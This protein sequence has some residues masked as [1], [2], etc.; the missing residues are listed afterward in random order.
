MLRKILAVS[1]CAILAA[2]LITP[3][4]FAKNAPD[5]K[6]DFFKKQ[7]KRLKFIKDKAAGAEK[8]IDYV[9]SNSGNQTLGYDAIVSLSPG[10]TIGT[11]TY[12]T[13]SNSR[14]NRQVSWRGPVYK[15]VHFIWMRQGDST[16]NSNRGTAYEVWDATEGELAFAGAGGGCDIH[17]RLGS[18]SNYSGYV[19]LDVDTENK[20]VIANHHDEGA[21]Y[22]TTVWYDFGAANCFFSP[23]KKAMPDSVMEYG[24][25]VDDI[26][27]GSGVFIWPQHEYQVYNGDTITHVFAHQTEDNTPTEDGSYVHYF[28][29]IG[30]D[31]MGYWEY[32]PMIVDTVQTISQCVAA[33]RTTGKVALVWAAPPGAFPG[34]NESMTRHGDDPDPGL[35]WVG[36]TCDI[37]YMTSNDMG[38][39]WTAKE[40]ITDYDSTVGGWLTQGDMSVLI[41]TDE[42]LHILYAA[43]EALPTTASA[44]GGLGD[45][46]HFFGARLLHWDEKHLANRPVSDANWD[47]PDSACTGGAWNQCSINKPMLSE[48]DGKF[49]AF[50]VQFLDIYNG[51]DNDCHDGR[52]DG[53]YSWN[54]TANGEIY[55]SVS[56]DEGFSWD[57]ARNLTQTYT[58]HCF[59]NEGEGVTVCEADH[60]VSTARYGMNSAG[61]NYGAAE[62]VPIGTSYS[63]DYYIDMTY[64]N[65]KFPGACMQN[66]GI[67]TTNPVKWV[68]VACVEPIPNPVVVLSPKRIGRPTWTH[69]GVQL[70]TVLFLEN[71][72]NADL[73]ISTIGVIELSN[74]GWLGIGNTGPITLDIDQNYSV[75]IPVYLNY[76]GTINDSPTPYVLEGYIVVTSDAVGGS[77][78]S[79]PVELIVADTIQEPQ[80]VDIRTS[81]KRLTLSNHGNLGH[82]GEGSYNLDFVGFDSADCDITENHSAAD[83]DRAD[84]YLYDASPFVLRLSGNDTLFSNAMFGINWYDEEAFVPLVSPTV[85]SLTDPDY[86]Y[87]TS[88]LFYT[89]DSLISVQSH[90]YAPSNLTNC[91]FMVVKNVFAL[92]ELATEKINNIILGDL[93][94]WDIPADS[95]SS[96]QSD[97][98]DSPNM[99]F[100][101]CYGYDYGPTDSFPNN[102]CTSDEG[103]VGGLSYYGGYKV[104]RCNPEDS[105]YAL[106]AQWTHLNSDW[107][108]PS[109]NFVASELYQKAIGA[110]GYETW[111]PTGDVTNSDSVAQDLNHVAVYGMYDLDFGDTLVFVKIL[112]TEY[113]G[114]VSAISQTITDARAWIAAHPAIFTYPTIIDELCGCC[115]VPG[116]ANHNGVVNILDITFTIAYLYKS[117]PA[118]A[119]MDEA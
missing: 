76:N 99:Q 24:V 105:I 39:S 25:D 83:G 46:S 102:D 87:G 88:S 64:I 111:E 51:I 23:Y 98:D 26:D 115:V 4:V 12:D 35:G 52:F 19:S 92:S 101:Y 75:E 79:L 106:Q 32:P 27:V 9:A 117:G 45:W 49:Y 93:V 37:F 118:P 113:D 67:W 77:V 13:Q 58:P 16:Y 38:D 34:D 11:T 82:A 86:D 65:D 3:S 36:R 103:R 18:G 21:G 10:M 84:V 15:D 30:S 60:Y 61:V 57:L 73:H 42:Y 71:I 48:C 22:H 5:N 90:I 28:R 110:S 107:V 7:A 100:M 112:A 114:G 53:S 33:S 20:A 1:L 109:G 62:I 43:R 68:R 104:P 91:D 40:N 70:D 56:G 14:I 85:D 80:W 2:I 72:G 55:M 119:C 47:I 116:D 74:P 69:H 108:Y 17:P 41:D 89:A 44:D 78:D 94:D 66:D 95:G 50:W 81:C 96:N 29:R 6:G 97:F 63:G 54:G 8:P 59:E 31:T